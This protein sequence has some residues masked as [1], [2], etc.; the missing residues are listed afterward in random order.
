MTGPELM[1]IR[2][3]LKWTRA[4]WA[5]HLGVAPDYISQLERGRRPIPQMTARHMRIVHLI[6]LLAL[7]AELIDK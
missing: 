7:E 1:E 5:E 6:Y 3:E 4:R 2:Q